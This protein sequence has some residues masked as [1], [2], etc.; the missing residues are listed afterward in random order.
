[1][2]KTRSAKKRLRQS[3]KRR[4]RN[5]MYKTRIKTALKKLEEG[6]GDIK[7]LLNEA[8]SAIDKAVKKGV[9]HRNKGA[10][11]KSKAA[12]IANKWLQQQT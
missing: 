12:E 4:L 8:Y 7:E 9:I 6:E 5:K 1:M 11:L 10:R 3:E 2:P